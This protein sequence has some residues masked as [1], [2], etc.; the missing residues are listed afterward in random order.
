MK[1]DKKLCALMIA[2]V[3][4]IA[5]MLPATMGTETSSEG[6][7]HIGNDKPDVGNIRLYLSDETTL[8]DT[9]D[10]T[11]EYAV[12]FDVSDAN[13]LNDIKEIE[14]VVATSWHADDSVNEHATYTW[15]A[16]AS[17]EWKKVGPEGTW[18]IN[19]NACKKPLYFNA[20]SGTFVLH[21]IPGKVAV[22]TIDGNTD[23]NLYVTVTDKAEDWDWT[24]KFGINMSWYGEISAVDTAYSFGGINLSD[25]DKPI[26]NPSD[27]KIDVSI[28]ANG[29]YKLESKSANWLNN[30]YMTTLDWDGTLSPGEFALKV[31]GSCSLDTF[32]YVRDT[33]TTITDFEN[34]PGPTAEGGEN[35]GIYQ[36]L[37]VASEGLLPGTYSGTYYVQMAN[38]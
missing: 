38:G 23:W 21:F 18:G 9:M 34:V 25:T 33:Y 11:S 27:T 30:G 4:S 29:N 14:V 15:T 26:V 28:I 12:K 13:T 17:P 3:V 19:E 16:G 7:F 1:M 32:N 35:R 10:P 20:T 37:C 6:S 31:D 36:W 24:Y 22:E 8:C 5:T 2:L